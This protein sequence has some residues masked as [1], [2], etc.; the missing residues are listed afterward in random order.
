MPLDL[1]KTFNIDELMLVLDI[2]SSLGEDTTLISPLYGQLFYFFADSS[3]FPIPFNMLGPW[4]C[5]LSSSL[6]ASFP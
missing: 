3:S 6:A 2:L 4:G 1:S 5:F